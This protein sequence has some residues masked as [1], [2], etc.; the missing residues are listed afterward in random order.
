MKKVYNIV[1]ILIL[2]V[3]ANA[4]VTLKP[5]AAYFEG[6]YKVLLDKPEQYIWGLGFEIQSDAIGSGNMGLPEVNTSV[7]HDLVPAERERLYN[8]M[9]KGFRYCRIAGGLYFRGT[10]PDE[11]ELRGRWDT[12]VDELKELIHKSGVEGISLEYWSPTPY[13]KANNRFVGRDG[14]NRLRCFGP[15]F[16]NDPVYKGDTAKFLNDF[17]ASLVNDIFYFERNEIPVKMWGLQ[18]EPSIDQAYSSCVYSTNEYTLAFRAIAPKIR[19]ANPNLMI[20]ADSEAGPSRHAKLISADPELRKNVDAWTWHEIGANSNQLIDEQEK[21]YKDTYGLPVFN[22]EYEYLRGG[23]SP[24]RCMNTVQNIMNWFTFVNSP[25]WFWIHALKPTGNSEAAGYAPGFWKPV[26]QPAVN[27]SVNQK[28]MPAGAGR[29][30]Y[31]YEVK[32]ASPELMG[33]SSVSIERGDKDKPGKAYSFSIDR[34]ADVYIAVN[35]VSGYVPPKDWKKTEYVITWDTEDVVYK[36]TFNAGMVQIPEN[37]GRDVTGNYGI[38]H[39]AII[40]PLKG[41]TV[42]IMCD[43][44]NPIYILTDIIEP[45]SEIDTDTIQP[46][47]WVYNNYNW[48][49]LAG[50]LKYMPWNSRRIAVEEEVIH[51]DQRILSYRTPEG[52]LV[53]VITNRGTEPFTF[54][55]STGISSVFKGYRYTPEEAGKNHEGVDVGTKT[56]EELLVTVPANTWDF[57]V[58]Q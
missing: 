3:S 54:K 19:A 43:K 53:V 8:D 45:R 27:A 4:Q 5:V 33:Y 7:P 44:Q 56:G 32:R 39:M 6:S 31:G 41:K 18:N 20:I 22:N 16:K 38:P 29:T 21:Y 50:F 15:N 30:I 40:V 17:S 55:I 47:H 48:F 25:T 34:K 35:A 46:G 26:N 57:W 2:S 49:A 10:T 28:G 36:K 9:L 13:W 51:K 58:Q 14:N 23:T 1:L 37:T 12:Q 42:E 24:A 11:K 52:K